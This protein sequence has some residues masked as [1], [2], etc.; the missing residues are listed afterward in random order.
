KIQG[1]ID[2]INAAFG[3][4]QSKLS[5]GA[6]FYP[7]VDPA[8][9]MSGCNWATDWLNCLLTLPTTICNDVDPIDK[10]PQIKIQPGAQ[11][12]AAWNA[13]WAPPVAAKGS[14]TPTEKGILAGEAALMNPPP[15]NTV[16]VVVT[17]GAPTC[18]MNE[19]AGVQ[20]LAQKNIKT[21]VI[22]LP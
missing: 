1:A 2:A 13:D 6:V 12:L 17:D 19:Q 18:G 7:H 8:T 22:G 5:A 9:G 10:P 21:Y 14:G 20:R 11:F 16:M 3:P 4:V 15:G